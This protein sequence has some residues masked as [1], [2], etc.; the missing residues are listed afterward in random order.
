MYIGIN[1][2]ATREVAVHGQIVHTSHFS[3][4][5]RGAQVGKLDESFQVKEVSF[6]A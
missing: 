1:R 3:Y 6:G 4:E 2:G 5:A